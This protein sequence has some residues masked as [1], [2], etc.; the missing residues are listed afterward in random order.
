MGA[1]VIPNP[2]PGYTVTSDGPVD[3]ARFAAGWSNSSALASALATSGAAAAYQRAWRDQTRAN[4]VQILLLRFAS[5][6]KART[7]VTAADRSLESSAVV[8]SGPLPSLRE[9]RRA[10]YVSRAGFGQAV[11]MRAGDY[12]ALLSF[13]SAAAAHASPITAAEVVRV[14]E[15]QHAAMARAPGGSRAAP[16]AKSG[17]SPTDVIWAV[18]AVVV[19]AAGVVTPLVLRRRRVR[20]VTLQS[21]QHERGDV[22]NSGANTPLR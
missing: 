22:A 15:A 21:R 6:G 19:L 17:P 2:G 12:V 1:I 16:A 20:E 11:V 9:A 18:L 10:T 7:F 14:A 13:V 3:D 4:G 5:A 8:S